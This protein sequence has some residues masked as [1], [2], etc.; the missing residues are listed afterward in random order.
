MGVG[1]TMAGVKFHEAHLLMPYLPP[2]HQ[3]D[4]VAFGLSA[5][6]LKPIL[7]SV[8]D[9][10]EPKNRDHNCNSRVGSQVGRD[11]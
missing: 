3:D 8:T 6:G 5:S 11:Q 2:Y 1:S 10:I 4:N 9:Q 7:K